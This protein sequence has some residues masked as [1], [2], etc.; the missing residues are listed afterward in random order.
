MKSKRLEKGEEIL[1]LVRIEGE[2]TREDERM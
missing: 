2:E 1:G